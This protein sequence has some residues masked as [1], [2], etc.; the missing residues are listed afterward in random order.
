MSRSC[1]YKDDL[2]RAV[3]NRSSLRESGMATQS[4]A[5]KSTSREPKVMQQG[6]QELELHVCS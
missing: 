3:Q 2:P 1:L 6:E 5:K 4:E